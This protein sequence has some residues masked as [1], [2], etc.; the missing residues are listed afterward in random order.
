MQKLISCDTQ[1]SCFDQIDKHLCCWGN[2]SMRWILIWISFS[3]PTHFLL[4]LLF[5][6]LFF[7]EFSCKLKLLAGQEWAKKL[8][9]LG[10]FNLSLCLFNTRS[11]PTFHLEITSFV[12]E[13][14][15]LSVDPIGLLFGHEVGSN[16]NAYKCSPSINFDHFQ[17]CK[18]CNRSWI[19]MSMG[20]PSQYRTA[21]LIDPSKH[22]WTGLNL[23]TKESCCFCNHCME[24]IYVIHFNLSVSATWAGVKKYIWD[25]QRNQRCSEGQEMETQQKGK[26]TQ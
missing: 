22:D 17:C 14:W 12:L 4:L 11:A 18:A 16:E 15:E 3:I 19:S 23:L 6:Y 9:S 13:D 20:F 5:I 2:Y 21:G 26:E 25:P 8:W 7:N 1:N 24:W 10:D